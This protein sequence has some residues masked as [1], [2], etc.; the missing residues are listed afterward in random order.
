MLFSIQE[1]VKLN[2]SSNITVSNYQAYNDSN[3]N[4]YM[5]WL[6]NMSDSL[7][8]WLGLVKVFMIF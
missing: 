2:Q 6:Q 4:I 3:V 5:Q 1:S 7:V 8:N